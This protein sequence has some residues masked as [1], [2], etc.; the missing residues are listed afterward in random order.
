M[1]HLAQARILVTPPWALGCLG[2]GD[3]H[4]CVDCVDWLAKA[5]LGSRS[6]GISLPV[7]LRG[8]QR[9]WGPCFLQKQM[10]K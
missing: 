7:P 5:A 9:V 6:L 8:G 2:G 3:A 4:V 10:T 1:P